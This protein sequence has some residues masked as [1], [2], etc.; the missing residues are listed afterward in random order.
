MQYEQQG[1]GKDFAPEYR[2][3]SFDG[4]TLAVM[5][6][7]TY[8]AESDT[9]KE[10]VLN[11][12]AL[13]LYTKYEYS[14][15][16]GGVCTEYR[17]AMMDEE[18]DKEDEYYEV[19]SYKKDDIVEESFLGP[20]FRPDVGTTYGIT[21]SEH[22]SVI[23]KHGEEYFLYKVA[24]INDNWS[25]EEERKLMEGKVIESA[26]YFTKEQIEVLEAENIIYYHEIMER[27]PDFIFPDWDSELMDP[28]NGKVVEAP[29]EIP[30]A[31]E[32]TPEQPTSETAEATP[33]ATAEATPEVTD[34]TQKPGS[35]GAWVSTG[36]DG[37]TIYRQPLT[38][39]KIPIN[40]QIPVE[41]ETQTWDYEGYLQITVFLYDANGNHI[42]GW[43]RVT[44][45][46]HTN[47]EYVYFTNVSL[48]LDNPSETSFSI[49]GSNTP[50]EGVVFNYEENS[51]QM[52]PANSLSGPAYGQV[53]TPDG[54][55]TTE[56]YYFVGNW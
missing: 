4:E 50:F 25:T 17:V 29:V 14:A 34:D 20:Y 30:E 7:S 28:V 55:I 43:G 22:P 45:L 10:Y 24:S 38:G 31:V 54:V 21:Y 16:G 2:T 49:M 11:G 3:E 12:D 44:D 8:D 32:T 6:R 39:A 33:E 18:Y 19:C 15:E 46:E 53:D 36:Y 40:G 48:C 23:T 5:N 41:V 56:E 13:N 42:E 9:M 35:R 27:H 47:Y 26:Y 51:G 52:P 37:R 1:Y